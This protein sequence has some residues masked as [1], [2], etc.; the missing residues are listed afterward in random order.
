MMSF[1][2][3]SGLLAAVGMIVFTWKQFKRGK[4]NKVMTITF[5]LSCLLICGFILLPDWY[6]VAGKVLGIDRPLDFIMVLA[7]MALFV[8][9]FELLYTINEQQKDIT[10][11]VREMGIKR[12]KNE[13]DMDSVQPLE[14]EEAQRGQED[15]DQQDEGIRQH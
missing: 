11:I 13:R 4:L 6:S 8:L 10:R 15:V 7:T 9:I 2:E 1:I 5:M 14:Q 3:F 12:E